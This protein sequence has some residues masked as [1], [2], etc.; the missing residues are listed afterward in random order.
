MLGQKLRRIPHRQ[1]SLLLLLGSFLNKVDVEQR[2]P[3]VMHN[4]ATEE[5]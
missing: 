5:R 1:R 3:L 4:L 2:P